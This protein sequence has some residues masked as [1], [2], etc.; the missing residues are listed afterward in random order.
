MMPFRIYRNS[1]ANFYNHG[2]LKNTDRHYTPAWFARLRENG[3][4]GFWLNVWLRHLVAFREADSAEQ[5][6]R[7]DTVK[8]LMERA[9]AHE[10][11]VWLFL[12]EPKAFPRSH[13]IWTRFPGMR[14]APGVWP[15]PHPTL[16]TYLL[17]TSSQEGK[18]YVRESA[19]R[20]HRTLPGLAGTIHINASESPTHCYCHTI[21][22]PGGMVFS[23]PQEHEG[24]ACPRCARRTPGE[25]LAEI[26]NLYQEGCRAA[27][28]RAPIV[29]WNWN[30]IMYAPHPQ[31]DLISRLHPGI[32]VMADFECGGTIDIYGKTRPVSEYSLIYVGP[33]KR[34]TATTECAKRHGL[35]HAAKVQLGATHELGTPANLPLIGHIHAKL[36][37]LGRTQCD[38]IFG[39]WNFGNRFTLNTAAVGKLLRTAT[40]T[41]RSAFLAGLGREYLGITA[42]APFVTAIAGFEEA[43]NFYPLCNEMIYFGPL[44]YALALPLD[45]APPRGKPLP[46]SCYPPEF[47]DAWEN[48]LGPYSFEDVIQGLETMAGR[49]RTALSFWDTAL[50]PTR[51]PRDSCLTQYRGEPVIPRH[52]DR[53]DEMEMVQAMRRALP[54]K[55]FEELPELEGLYGFRRLQEWGN[56]WFIL[57]CVESAARIFRNYAA[58]RQQ[59]PDY[60]ATLRALQHAEEQTL[61]WCLPLLRL[62]ARLG[63]HLE[64]QAYFVTPEILERKLAALRSALAENQAADQI[65]NTLHVL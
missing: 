26:L 34:Y 4:N 20:L 24:I 52:A 53:L 38:G 14:G 61:Q 58:K 5:I 16:E 12:N 62:D 43:F 7:Q 45:D 46:V 18:D 57:A 27:G 25:V 55:A 47:G 41:D 35:P 49:L 10:V 21:T 37:S 32:T 44:N 17:C 31:E 2:D 30:W 29:A 19:E 65:G 13:R 56:A 23:S 28:S 40:D 50:F 48:C 33:S 6:R 54:A 42:P 51:S 64:C 1:E 15:M 3:F 8:R 39:T 59:H 9:A 11:G 63:L 36:T 22:N 60:P